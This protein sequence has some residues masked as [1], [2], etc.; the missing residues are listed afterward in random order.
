V[1]TQAARNPRSRP[2]ANDPLNSNQRATVNRSSF[3]LCICAQARSR[4][5]S[6]SEEAA[7]QQQEQPRRPSSSSNAAGGAAPANQQ[8]RLWEEGRQLAEEGERAAWHEQMPRSIFENSE[9]L[10]VG[11]PCSFVCSLFSLPASRAGWLAGWQRFIHLV[12]LHALPY[13]G[14]NGYLGSPACVSLCTCVRL[15]LQRWETATQRPHAG[16]LSFVIFPC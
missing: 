9:Q 7:A 6:Q 14:H 10:Q 15:R 8:P 3:I 12:W 5:S 1:A 11:S 2:T 4:T 13:L 16:L